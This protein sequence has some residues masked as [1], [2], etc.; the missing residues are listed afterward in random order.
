M[1][2]D[3][4]ASLYLKFK[5]AELK[6]STYDKYEGIVRLRLLPYFSGRNIEDI[7]VSDIKLWL[8]SIQ[9]VGAKSKKHYLAC[10]NGI[11]KE[12][13]YDEVIEKNPIKRIKSIKYTTPDIKPFSESEVNLIL[14]HAE[15]FNFKHYLAI[16]FFTGM[17][18]GEIVALKQ[19]E[20]DLENNLIYINSTR[21]RFGETTPKTR[22]SIR[23]IPILKVL[24]PYLIA[25]LE[26]NEHQYLYVNQ[27]GNPYRDT[28]VFVK[29]FWIPT[30][31]DLGIEYRRLYNTRHTYATNM[32]LSG[33]V[34]PH[35][36]AQLL[37]HSTSEMVFKVYA[38]YI[39][40][41]LN[42]FNC[43]VEL[44]GVGSNF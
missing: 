20:I 44:Y 34:T 31:E 43:D 26:A 28:N 10:L 8:L 42:T 25:L 39:E 36:L 5:E 23:K 1:T 38:R 33:H 19:S 15:N 17:R 2:F 40:S 32:L 22:T 30:L 29:S 13:Y 7:K 24:R 14:N 11:F 6:T 18:S 35:E 27:Y 21:S 4:Y 3:K 41:H 16:A 9:D 37:G 12:A